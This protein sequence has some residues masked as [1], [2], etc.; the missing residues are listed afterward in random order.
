LKGR[1]R[2][3]RLRRSPLRKFATVAVI[4][5]LGACSGP[6]EED[7]RN[8]ARALVPSNSSIVREVAGD[9]VELAPSPSCFHIYFVMDDVGQQVRAAAVMRAARASGWV[10]DH[11]DVLPGGIQLRFHT[12]E[13][14]ALVSLWADDRA[15]QC[16]LNPNRAC[17]D[18]VMVE[19]NYGI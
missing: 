12:D 10:L 16:A 11:Q 1:R 6:G 8:S 7:L 15:D 19:G 5:A 2:P 14:T 13:F 3:P 17:A 9:C 4:A 18:I